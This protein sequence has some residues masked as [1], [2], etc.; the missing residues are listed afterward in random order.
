MVLANENGGLLVCEWLV[1]KTEGLVWRKVDGGV[2]WC[3]RR[4][5]CGAAVNSE[6]REEDRWRRGEILF[7]PSLFFICFY[8][9]WERVRRVEKEHVAFPPS[10]CL[11]FLFCVR[12]RVVWRRGKVSPPSFFF[13]L[14]S[15]RERFERCQQRELLSSMWERI[16]SILFLSLWP[17]EIF[18]SIWDFV[19]GSPYLSLSH[20]VS[21]KDLQRDVGVVIRGINQV[22]TL[23]NSS[24]KGRVSPS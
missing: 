8:L 23:Y 3:R 24:Y 16:N 7:F 15:F 1:K 17:L 12:G 10:F 20:G 18:L 13:L 6:G 4:R 14:F 11:F 5:D 22:T 2:R 21:S 19:S 9:F